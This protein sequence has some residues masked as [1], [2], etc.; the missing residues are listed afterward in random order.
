MVRQSFYI[1]STGAA[2]LEALKHTLRWIAD[3]SCVVVA[4]RGRQATR[5]SW[6]VRATRRRWK[7]VASNS[8]ARP[9]RF[10]TTC[11]TTGCTTVAEC[12]RPVARPSTPTGVSS[13]RRSRSATPA[14]TRA[15][16]AT[17]SDSRPRPEPTSMSPVSC[18]RTVTFSD[19]ASREGTAIG[20]VRPPVGFRSLF[21]TKGG[22][23]AEWIACWTQAQEG[24]GSNRSRDAVG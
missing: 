21:W 10:R 22:W 13:W 3:W 16:P 9:R 8:A 19:R 6:F 17:G 20:R 15:V 5:T 7:A 11:R 14:G 4:V 1:S 12:R 18:L 2:G 23:V 24:L